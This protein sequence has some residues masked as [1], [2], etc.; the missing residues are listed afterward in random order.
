MSKFSTVIPLLHKEC[1]LLPKVPLLLDTGIAVRSLRSEHIGAIISKRRALSERLNSRTKCILIQN[2]E[3]QPS[4]AD[5]EAAGLFGPF[6]L[7]V[8]ASMGSL[9]SA[10][11]FTVK[12]VRTHSV[13][14]VID[15][16][17]SN[18]DHLSDYEIDATTSPASVKTLY[19][20]TLVAMSKD[21]GL[22][23]TVRRFNGALSKTIREDKVIDIAICL[24]SIFSSQTEISFRFS[25]YNAILAEDDSSKRASLFKILKRLYKE[26][27]NLVHG[28]KGLDA[29]WID[30]QW[31]TIVRT[32]KL[33]LLKKI[34]FLQNNALA[35]W[36]EHLDNLALGA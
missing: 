25:L 12:H 31:D 7:N 18:L 27:S 5:I 24:E 8:F 26:R 22:W 36:Q 4:R 20:S 21:A 35:D 19:A 16:A 1:K 30:A 15:L 34:D 14:D 2:E 6:V 33:S 10:Q 3:N 13:V 28:N 9:S 11:A 23:I 29:D 17:N 32:A